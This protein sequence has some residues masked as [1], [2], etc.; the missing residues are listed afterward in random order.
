VERMERRDLIDVALGHRPAS[1]VVRG[2]K[3]VNV[4][5]REIYPADIAILGDRVAAVGSVGYAVGPQTL[6]ID[7]GGKYVTP[8]FIDQHIHVHETQLNI[9]EF[10]SA[11]LPRGTTGICTDLYGEMV[12]G[13]VKAVRTCL[14]AAHHLPLK[15]WFM[16]GMPGFYQNAPFGHTGWPTLEDMLEMLEWPECQGMDDSFAS[17]IVAGDPPILQLIDAVQSRGKKVCGGFPGCGG[18]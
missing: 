9:V 17:K 10:A 4:L 5:T 11:V 18:E 14:D 16:L 12:V 7:A 2:G 3:L 15:V 13:G 6:V 8:G 1:L